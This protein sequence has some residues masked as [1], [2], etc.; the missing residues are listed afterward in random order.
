M[1]TWALEKTHYLLRLSLSG[2]NYSLVCF[3]PLPLTSCLLPGVMFE[4]PWPIPTLQGKKTGGRVC[5]QVCVFTSNP[6][7]GQAGLLFDGCVIQPSNNIWTLVT[8][9]HTTECFL[10]S[11][12]L[13]SHEHITSNNNNKRTI[14]G[15]SSASHFVAY[16]QVLNFLLKVHL[17]RVYLYLDSKVAPRL[18]T[19]MH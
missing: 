6:R 4:A 5:V 13:V 11:L 10:K 19:Q 12:S 1:L 3:P 8:L 17:Y 2:I 9:T 18:R 15:I 14:T 7:R 16:G